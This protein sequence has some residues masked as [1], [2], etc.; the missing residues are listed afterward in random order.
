MAG[1][2]I[3]VRDITSPGFALPPGPAAV[4]AKKAATIIS[5][6]SPHSPLGLRLTA[7]KVAGS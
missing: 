4:A 3:G 5:A 1:V 6:L 7:N 2:L